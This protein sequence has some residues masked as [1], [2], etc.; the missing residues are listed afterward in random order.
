MKKESIKLN[1]VHLL[2]EGLLYLRDHDKVLQI[3]HRFCLKRECVTNIKGNL[4]NIR[5]LESMEVK[6][7]EGLLLTDDERDTV[8]NEGFILN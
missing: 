2:V 6:E 7:S 5:N 1:D 8:I 4:N 3:K